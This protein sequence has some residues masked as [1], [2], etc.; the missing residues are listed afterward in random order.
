MVKVAI[1]KGNAYEATTKALK[2]TNFKKFILGK[3]RIAIKPNLSYAAPAKLGITTDVNVVRAILDQIPK[4]EKAIVVEG[5]AGPAK[6]ND[7][8]EVCG[9]YELEKEYGVRILD[10]NHDE[11]INIP[12]SE[13]MTLKGIEISKTVLDSDFVIS[14]GK[15]KIHSIARISATLKNMMGVCSKRQKLKIHAFIP[16]SLVDLISVLM[17]DFGVIDGI[18]ANEIDEVV[19][20]PIK[21]GIVL[22]SKDCVALDCVAS[23]VMGIHPYNVPY[24]HE[25]ILKELSIDNLDEIEIIGEK[26]ENLKRNFRIGGF[27]VRS[28][29][30]KFF[31][32]MLNKTGL[33]SLLYP[34][35]Y[36]IFR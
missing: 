15:L 25:I 28:R 23:E 36:K 14:V 7:A 31:G 10:L 22:A 27:N 6:T 2:L 34:Y 1:T 29:G 24:L 33:F 26:I 35:V 4:P 9:Y 16:R 11:F 17:P 18:V 32:I 19:P 20:H 21:M 3:S 13:P 30:Q 12:I 5:S 8:F